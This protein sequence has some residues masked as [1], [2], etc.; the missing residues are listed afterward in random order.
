M[1]LCLRKVHKPTYLWFHSGTRP[2]L[3][4][5]LPKPLEILMTRCWHGN[6]AER[7]AMAEVCRIMMYMFQVFSVDGESII[8]YPWKIMKHIK[9]FVELNF[10]KK[11]RN[12]WQ[13]SPSENMK[14][15]LKYLKIKIWIKL[16][17]HCVHG[18]VI[19]KWLTSFKPKSCKNGCIWW[20]F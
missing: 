3:I 11:K 2:P 17:L 8:F 1:K 19:A 12:Q 18:S 5:N 15:H 16:S 20:K 6:P 9:S 10:W 7:P 14:P 13:I 4:R